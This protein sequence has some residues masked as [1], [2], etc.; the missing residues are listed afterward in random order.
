MNF[1]LSDEH[2]MLQETLRAFVAKEVAPPLGTWTR[3]ASSHGRR[4]M[5]WRNWACWG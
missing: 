2:R 1:D 5:R 3:A 4:C